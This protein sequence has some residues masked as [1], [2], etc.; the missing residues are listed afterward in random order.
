[1]PSNEAASRPH[2]GALLLL[3]V[4]L[5][6]SAPV[7]ADGGP[8][9]GASG[10]G[11]PEAIGAPA[12]EP[13]IAYVSLGGIVP[14]GLP[15]DPLGSLYLWR[16]PA[17]GEGRLRGVLSGIANE[18]RWDRRLRPGAGWESVVTFDSM[19][20]PWEQAE[21]VGGQ[22][23]R[24]GE[25]KWYQARV[26]A[27]LGWH[28]PFGRRETFN[29]LDV[30]LTLEAGALWF[31]A[32]SETAPGFVL[33]VDTFEGRLHL[34]A[35]ADALSRNDVL[36]LTKGWSAGVDGNWGVRSRWEPWGDP[37]TGLVT[38][39]KGWVGASGFAYLALP[40]DGPSGRQGLVAS[41]HAGVG[42]GQDRFSSFRLGGG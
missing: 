28:R 23:Y 35:R 16:E 33:P 19:T 37:S 8:P 27:G 20:L 21:V 38:G 40:L 13:S 30:A 15:A 29:G 17:T 5:G 31:Q 26:G 42:S 32:G 9:P 1:M 12:A 10:S 6:A 7:R 14:A 36:L 41:L 22:E 34:R 25:L 11:S 18:L 24:P 3:S 4:L 2:P 39:G